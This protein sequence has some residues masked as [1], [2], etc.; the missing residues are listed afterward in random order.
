M[1]KI[2][3]HSSIAHMSFA[4]LGLYTFNNIGIYGSLYLMLGHGIVAA[5]AFSSV[6]FIYDRKHTRATYYLAGSQKFFFKMQVVFFLTFLGNIAFPTTCNFIGETCIFLSLIS[7]GPVL[8]F[9]LG[10]TTL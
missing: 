5:L 4:L 8:V 7:M 3:A 1:K 2:I 9:L 6:G 10:L